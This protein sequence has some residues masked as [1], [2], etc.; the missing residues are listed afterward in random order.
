MD[1]LSEIIKKRVK[2]HK[3]R[4]ATYFIAT[5]ML[6]IVGGLA[7]FVPLPAEPYAERVVSKMLS[8][9]GIYRPDDCVVLTL[10]SDI[11]TGLGTAMKN[12][13]DVATERKAS[14]FHTHKETGSEGGTNDHC[15]ETKNQSPGQ[16]QVKSPEESIADIFD[17]YVT[18]YGKKGDRQFESR[19]KE[20]DSRERNAEILRDHMARSS[21][22]NIVA[23]LTAFFGCAFFAVMCMLAGRRHWRE[24]I[25]I[26]KAATRIE[27]AEALAPFT[28]YDGDD[29]G[30]LTD[31]LKDVQ[32][33][34]SS[35][36][37]HVLDDYKSQVN[38]ILK[39]CETVL[40]TMTI[41][42]AEEAPNQALGKLYSAYAEQ[43]IALVK[44]LR[45]AQK[46]Y[47]DHLDLPQNN[48]EQEQIGIAL[49]TLEGALEFLQPRDF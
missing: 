19:L 24:S 38:D 18:Y 27:V 5:G 39:Q 33:E 3:W 43:T 10:P 13:V 12:I 46:T 1:S 21:W 9:F 35:R 14:D 17:T 44:E 6:T 41:K 26:D 37:K 31:R 47:L 22:F 29:R 25:L 28:T 48:L 11:K 23:R 42:N 16:R 4:Q 49:R 32:E 2:D 15:N 7:F 34:V 20:R 8:D 40:S 30:D 45:S 36:H